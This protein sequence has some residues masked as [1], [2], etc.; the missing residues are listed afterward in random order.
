MCALRLKYSKRLL[1][2]SVN[3]MARFCTRFGRVGVA[4]AFFP[5]PRPRFRAGG[6]FCLGY[7]M[8]RDA[9]GSGRSLTNRANGEAGASWRQ[10]RSARDSRLA[11]PEM[12]RLTTVADICW[13]LSVGA[14]MMFYSA[15]FAHIISSFPAQATSFVP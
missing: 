4:R 13:A 3:R 2:F 12:V 1:A 6:G 14:R 11:P 10:F 9:R 5:R 8:M 15:V 7:K